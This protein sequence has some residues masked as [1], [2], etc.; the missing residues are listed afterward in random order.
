MS[1]KISFVSAPNTHFVAMA[2]ADE[3][4]V[5]SSF[6]SSISLTDGVTSEAFHSVIDSPGTC[7]GLL[8]P[9]EVTSSFCAAGEGIKVTGSGSMHNVTSS[10]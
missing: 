6:S 1:T 10:S 8:P 4:S 7:P 5:S 9:T 3:D 2:L